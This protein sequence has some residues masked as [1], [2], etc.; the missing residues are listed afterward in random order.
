[1]LRDDFRNL[2]AKQKIRGFL[3]SDKDG[4]AILTPLF[5]FNTANKNDKPIHEPLFSIIE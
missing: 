3:G 4:Y 2:K 5:I 1:M